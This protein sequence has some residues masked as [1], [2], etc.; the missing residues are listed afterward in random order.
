MNRTRRVVR[1][2]TPA[3]QNGG[4]VYHDKTVIGVLGGGK[5]HVKL[6]EIIHGTYVLVDRFDA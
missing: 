2:I 4:I 6:K 1:V 3:L 5:P